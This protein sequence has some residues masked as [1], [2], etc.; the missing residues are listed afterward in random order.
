MNTI[1]TMILHKKMKYNNQM[2]INIPIIK[3]KKQ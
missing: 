3:K 2:N 1:L